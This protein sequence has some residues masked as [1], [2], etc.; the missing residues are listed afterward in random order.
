MPMSARVRSMAAVV[1]GVL[2]AAV[3][4]GSASALDG[5]PVLPSAPR[6]AVSTPGSTP[7]SEGWA[8]NN[9]A[10]EDDLLRYYTEA[11]TNMERYNALGWYVYASHAGPL[12]LGIKAFVIS[13]LA[14]R[15]SSSRRMVA[16]AG[17]SPIE[18]PA[19]LPYQELNMDALEESGDL[20]AN[21]KA[22]MDDMRNR[23][24]CAAHLLDYRSAV[25]KAKEEDH[26]WVAIFED[27]IMLTAPPAEASTRIQRAL[28]QVPDSADAIYMEYCWYLHPNPY[29]PHSLNLNP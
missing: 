13:H 23:Q 29:N 1:V 19:T 28:V 18:F 17:F 2:C 25:A 16:A 14:E 10:W 3:G 21:F 5:A 20:V 6:C 24:I 4:A 15:H 8:E 11:M 26:D 9:T 7:G 27:D 12:D 22:D